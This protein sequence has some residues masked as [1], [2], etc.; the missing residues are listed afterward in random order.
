VILDSIIY[1]VCRPNV[2][3]PPKINWKM[4]YVSLDKLK[5]Y[6]KHFSEE[7]K[8]TDKGNSS[9]SGIKIYKCFKIKIQLY[10]KTN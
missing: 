2:F 3:F 9:G 7:K 10:L 1:S 5:K 6:V 4:H 8:G